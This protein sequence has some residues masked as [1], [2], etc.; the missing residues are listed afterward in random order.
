LSYR[1][2]AAALGLRE[3]SIGSL[4]VRGQRKF[5]KIYRKNG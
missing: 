4:I 1:E 3:S 5:L 2:I